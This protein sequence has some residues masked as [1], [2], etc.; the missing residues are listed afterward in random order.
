VGKS[1][2]KLHDDI[3]GSATGSE[4]THGRNKY[5]SRE[6]RVRVRHLLLREWDPIGSSG[7]GPDD[8]YDAYADKAYAMLMNEATGA[9]IAAY[10]YNVATEHMG[11][12][13]CPRLAQRSDH[14]A[15]ILVGMR[16]EFESH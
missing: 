14:V 15:Q 3:C 12:S 2:A 16:T 9:A 4:M 7:V 8:E 13:D 1:L 6:N 5:Q 10:L 11:L